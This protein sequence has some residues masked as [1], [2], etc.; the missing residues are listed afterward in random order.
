MKLWLNIFCASIG[1]FIVAYL[2]GLSILSDLPTALVL[3]A[4]FLTL[5]KSVKDGKFLVGR[6]ISGAVVI[7]LFFAL[8]FS[9]RNLLQWN[10]DGAA[11]S[12]KI[13]L[14]HL[15]FVAGLIVGHS[16]SSYSAA[17]AQTYAILVFFVPLLFFLLFAQGSPPSNALSVFNRNSF[18]GFTLAAS[19]L[20]IGFGSRKPIFSL[21]QYL[22][23]ISLSLIFNTTLGALLS[24][25]LATL[26]YVG[27]K[28]L[29]SRYGLGVVVLAAVLI[30]APIMLVVSNHQ[31][32]Q[33]VEVVERLRFVGGTFVNLFR[34]YTGSWLDLD[35]AT[36]VRFAADGELD[37]SAVFRLLHWLNIVE[38]LEA[39]HPGAIWF[40]GGA[41]W[42]ERNQNMLVYPLAAHNEYVRLTVEQGLIYSIPIFVMLAVAAYCVRKN[43]IFIPILSSLI[44]FGSE[45]LLNNFVSTAMF[46]FVF[47]HTFAAE[48]Q[49]RV[50]SKHL[51]RTTRSAPRG[52]T[53]RSFCQ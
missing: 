13:I 47:G 18:A 48:R 22:I 9:T 15:V 24:F 11:L 52:S 27:P 39:R 33:G 35:M 50:V 30:S 25:L 51:W 49:R 43:I 4:L 12:I 21:T 17:Q 45:N 2:S 29:I 26:V 10:P 28:A 7:T 37:M 6:S 23:V 20:L 32:L 41:D 19:A 1:V 40:G 16:R 34:G 14:Y 8:F 53:I 5:M 42:I 44:Y 36:A 31:I 38:T 3:L 46:F